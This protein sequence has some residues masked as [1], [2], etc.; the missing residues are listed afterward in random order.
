[1]STGATTASDLPRL[2]Q[3]LPAQS[4]ADAAS[5]G[6]PIAERPHPILACW[7]APHRA[8]RLHVGLSRRLRAALSVAVNAFSTRDGAI[9]CWR[10]GHQE[11]ECRCQ[12]SSR[13]ATTA[14]APARV[15]KG[16]S[17]LSGINN[18]AIDCTIRNMHEHGAEL[19]VAHGRAH[20][21]R[22]PALRADRRHRLPRDTALAQAGPLR[23]ASSPAP[24]RSRLALSA[25]RQ[26][27]IGRSKLTPI[28]AGLRQHHMRHARG[29]PR[30]QSTRRNVVGNANVSA[31]R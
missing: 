26:P 27:S 31:K 2:G 5:A 16:A 29:A 21:Q 14:G 4:R 22:V 24:S 17:I 12:P 20:P 15:L 30:R 3:H 13:K 9:L 8:R 28:S 23:R 6:R 19:R 25:E 11:S 7:P 10:P 18:S 1:M